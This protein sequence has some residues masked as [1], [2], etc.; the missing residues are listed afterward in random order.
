MKMAGVEP[1]YSMNSS[2]IVFTHL[3]GLIYKLLTS[4]YIKTPIRRQVPTKTI[5]DFS[6]RNN[7]LFLHNTLL[8]MPP[9]IYKP[10]YYIYSNLLFEGNQ[11]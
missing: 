7:L 8:N 9:H 6:F 3:I 2:I 11:I 4:V 1:I 5:F 10:I